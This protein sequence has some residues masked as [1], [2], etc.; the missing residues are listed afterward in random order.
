MN[1]NVIKIAK[2][3]RVFMEI[4]HIKTKRSH[5]DLKELD[6]YFPRYRAVMSLVKICD[7]TCDHSIA[8]EIGIQFFQAKIWL[9]EWA[10]ALHGI[11]KSALVSILILNRRTYT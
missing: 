9:G 3:V 11:Y 10:I 4:E 2:T 1:Y 7:Q 8:W 6:H 5:F